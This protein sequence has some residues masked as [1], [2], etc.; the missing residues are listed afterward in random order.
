VRGSI[1]AL[2]DSIEVRAAQCDGKCAEIPPLKD[3]ANLT[4]SPQIVRR[5]STVEETK[6][7]T[8][9][10]NISTLATKSRSAAIVM[11]FSANICTDCNVRT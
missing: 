11:T 1:D 6:Q 3:K 9:F 10:F 5:T 8:R 4:T 7:A 2:G